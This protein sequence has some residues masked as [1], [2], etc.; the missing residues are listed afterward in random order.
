MLPRIN[1]QQRPELSHHRILV[2]VRLDPNRT[3]LR[4]LDQPRPAGALDAGQSGV[5]LLLH[6][7]EAAVGG[8]DGFGQVAG[9]WLAA[10]AGFGG[11]VLPEERVVCVAACR[12]L[13]ASICRRLTFVRL[14]V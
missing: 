13:S 8:V 5:E 6:G 4:V 14:S 1:A 2:R 3:G 10:A 11:E 9:G 12:V 7:V